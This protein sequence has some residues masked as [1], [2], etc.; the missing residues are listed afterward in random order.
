MVKT[1]GGE[2]GEGQV[3]KAVVLHV[4]Q[5]GLYLKSEEERHSLLLLFMLSW[6]KGF[7]VHENV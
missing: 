1:E 6:K 7:E 3:I 5:F 4:K 2:V